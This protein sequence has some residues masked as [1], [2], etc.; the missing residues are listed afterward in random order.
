MYFFSHA[1]R[2][3]I[4]DEFEYCRANQIFK[5]AETAA[6]SLQIAQHSDAGYPHN[7][8]LYELGMFVV[9]N[10]GRV[11]SLMQEIRDEYTRWQP[12]P[13]DQIAVPYILWK[14]RNDIRPARLPGTVY[15]NDFATFHDRKHVEAK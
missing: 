13:N 9:R 4:Y 14:H 8:G 15:R 3:C 12:C 2:H 6:A 5:P 10:S 1:R 11:E 7:A